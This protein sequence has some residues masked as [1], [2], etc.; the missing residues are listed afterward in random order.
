MKTYSISPTSYKKDVRWIREYMQT[1]I[2][3][4]DIEE[5][6]A[7]LFEMLKQRTSELWKIIG[8]EDATGSVR[9]KALKELR[10]EGTEL[11][12]ILQAVGILPTERIT[13]LF[14]ANE[15]HVVQNQNESKEI[16]FHWGKPPGDQE[17]KDEKQ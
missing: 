17:T 15:I 10:G 13:N 6:K 3:L 8:K 4:P 12:R 2:K 16:H 14:A 9:V 5:A 7:I 11:R 1:E